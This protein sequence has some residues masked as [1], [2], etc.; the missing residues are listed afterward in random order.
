MQGTIYLLIFLFIKVFQCS[1]TVT[2]ASM[3]P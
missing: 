2:L 1:C 3:I